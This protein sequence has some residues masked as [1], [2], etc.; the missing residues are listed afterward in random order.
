MFNQLLQLF[1]LMCCVQVESQF[2][3]HSLPSA[4]NMDCH[5]VALIVWKQQSQAKICNFGL[6]ILVQQ[7]VAC[8]DVSMNDSW[9]S[10]RMQV[11]DS[12][13]HSKAYVSSYM[14]GQIDIPGMFYINRPHRCVVRRKFEISF[15]RHRLTLQI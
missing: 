3:E 6:Q 7:N 12:I 2:G 14:P 13:S 9:L 1:G 8:F 11:V 4:S 10:K 5:N 15:Y